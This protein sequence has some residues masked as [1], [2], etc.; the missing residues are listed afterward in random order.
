MRKVSGPRLV[1]N[2]SSHR[3]DGPP[4]GLKAHSWRRVGS[5]LVRL[6]SQFAAMDGE[7]LSA[8]TMEWK[9]LKERF[10]AGAH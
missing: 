7:Q 10:F 5:A 9:V 2:A 6:K 4:L 8:V 3:S 1:G